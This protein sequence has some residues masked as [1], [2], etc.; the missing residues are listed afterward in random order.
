MDDVDV[1][2]NNKNAMDEFKQHEPIQKT[3]FLNNLEYLYR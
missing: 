2:S 1:D 3:K